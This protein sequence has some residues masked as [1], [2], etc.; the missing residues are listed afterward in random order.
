MRTVE[1]YFKYKRKNT[2]NRPPVNGFKIE[3]KL[4]IEELSLLFKEAGITPDDIGRGCDDYCLMRDGDKGHYEYGN[5]RF[6]K[7]SQN[8]HDATA[9]EK[10]GMFG[11]TGNQ[12]PNFGI[13]WSDERKGKLSKSISGEN[14]HNF[15]KETPDDVRDKISK[16]T[17]GIPKPRIECEV[18]G[19]FMPAHTMKRHMNGPN[20]K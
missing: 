10:N 12:S 6:G 19:K 15:G 14:H 8:T 5:C 13:K 20:C 17:S 2:R 11:K 9:G 3:F 4:T 7:V 1:E 18:C 16:S